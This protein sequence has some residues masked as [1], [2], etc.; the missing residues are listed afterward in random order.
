MVYRLAGLILFAGALFSLSCKSSD[1]VDSVIGS[2]NDPNSIGNSALEFTPPTYDFGNLRA[3]S[4]S[5]SH[6]IT[7]HNSANDTVY[8]TGVSGSNSNFAIDSDTC[9]RSPAGFRAGD[10]CTITVSFTPKASGTLA[11]AVRVNYGVGPSAVGEFY[12]SAGLSGT[13]VSPV[14]FPGLTSVDNVQCSTAKVHWTS[15]TDIGA[16]LVFKVLNDGSKVL[17]GSAYAANQFTVSSLTPATDYTFKVL[18]TDLLGVIVDNS[19]TQTVTTAAGP[20]VTTQADRTFPSSYLTQGQAMSP[21]LDYNNTV[22]GNDTDMT[23]TCVFDQV[24]DGAVSASTACSTLPGT[25]TFSS[26]TGQ[27]A[28]TPNTSALGPYEIKVTGSLYGECASSDVVVLDVKENFSMSNLVALFDPQFADGRT[29]NTNSPFASTWKNLSSA[30][31]S[32]NGSLS[33]GTWN[34]AAWTG[35]GSTSSPYGLRFTGANSNRV[36]FGSGLS[37]NSD[38]AFHLWA[39]PTNVSASGTVLISTGG[40]S[41]DGFVL[42]QSASSPGKVEMIVGDTSS[43]VYSTV[44]MGLN[45]VGYWKLDESSGTSVADSSGNSLTGSNTN[46][47]IAAAAAIPQ[48]TSYQFNGAATTYVN[49]PDSNTLDLTGSISI[50]LWVYP[51]AST[52]TNGYQ[53]LVG[54]GDGTGGYPYLLSFDSGT[55]YPSLYLD[56]VNTMWSKRSTIAAVQN[57]WNHIV[58]VYDSV[59]HTITY[60]VNNQATTPLSVSTGALNTSASVLEIGNMVVHGY[61]LNGRIDEVALFNSALSASDVTSMY[62]SGPRCESSVTLQNDVW[63]LFSG[64]YNHTTGVGQLFI[65]SLSQCSVT[66]PGTMAPGSKNLSFGAELPSG[67]SA[68]SGDIGLAAIFSSG[69]STTVGNH[70]QATLPRYR[71]SASVVQAGL[72]SYYDAKYVNGTSFPGGFCGS[73]TWTDLSASTAN[74]SL[75]NFN[76]TSASGWNGDGTTGDPYRLTVT[77]G[78]TDYVRVPDQTSLQITGDITVMVI[79]KPTGSIGNYQGMVGKGNGTPNYGYLYAFSTG[80]TK[81]SLY[82]DAAN[83]TW[84]NFATTALPAGTW[85]ISAA[86]FKSSTKT[87]SYYLNGDTDGS[88]VLTGASTYGS[89]S[90]PLEIGTMIDNTYPFDG[91]IAAVLIYNSTLSLAEIKQNCMAFESRFSGLVCVP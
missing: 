10:S 74:G 57:Q 33:A 50:A 73:T 60:Y 79:V 18:A 56:P 45:P 8:V 63:Y 89:N 41:G 6:Q 78:A 44:V 22:T 9:P 53:G 26:T 2:T 51:M 17:M 48:G 88:Y 86:S 77:T 14:T 70:Y 69:T 67:A 7:V 47:T 12:S 62:N 11:I 39:K 25:A 42:R 4:D 68:W 3:N 28:W 71:N 58:A 30:G 32:L 20:V 40:A 21:V 46:A 65:N 87:L 24:V 72:V 49:I 81:P 19:A 80:T 83:N 54:K 36:D 13:G 91:D 34:A 15:Q 55:L 37:S 5:A 16:Y 76:C 85:S 90:L 27:L 64:L 52:G 29:I 59:A 31:S 23:Y 82:L 66:F 84:G 75:L 43:L 1:A 35:V 61:P 38:L